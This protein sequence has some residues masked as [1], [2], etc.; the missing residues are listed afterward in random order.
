MYFVAFYIPILTSSFNIFSAVCTVFTL[1]TG[2][3]LTFLGDLLQVHEEK[4]YWCTGIIGKQKD[5]QK[6]FQSQHLRN[7]KTKKWLSTCYFC[8]RGKKNWKMRVFIRN[9]GKL[10]QNRLENSFQRTLAKF[11]AQYVNLRCM[12]IVCSVL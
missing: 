1:Y 2:I 10:K 4:N 6:P 12:S 11:L 8:L 5:S 3:E 7:L 9:I